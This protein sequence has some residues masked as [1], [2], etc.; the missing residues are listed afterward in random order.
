MRPRRL[1]ALLPSMLA[2]VI[3]PAVWGQ[4]PDGAAILPPKATD[5]PDR[6]TLDPSIV[7]VRLVLGVGDEAVRSWGGRVKVDRG[8]VLARVGATLS[9]PQVQTVGDTAPPD[10]AAAAAHLADTERSCAAATRA[11]HQREEAATALARALARIEEALE[12]W[13]PVR[14]EHERI[15]AIARLVRGSGPD[16][17]TDAPRIRW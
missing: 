12:A 8:E 2:V 9:D 13:E 6:R 14:T 3:A 5:P 11:L 15:E 7:A 1:L 4:R 10:L 16:V 17:Q